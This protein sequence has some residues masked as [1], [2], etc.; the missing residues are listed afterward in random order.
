[1]KEII[2]RLRRAAIE[3]FAHSDLLREAAD[4]IEEM[5]AERE[6]GKWIWDDEGFH[7]SL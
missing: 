6:Q 2:E 5:M 1:M 7:C 4:T 3:S